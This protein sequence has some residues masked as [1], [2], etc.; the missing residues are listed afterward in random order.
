MAAD[1]TILD[2]GNLDTGVVTSQATSNSITPAVGDIVFWEAQS[3]VGT[4]AAL[5]GGG[6]T[7]SL[8]HLEAPGTEFVAVF[9]AVSG[10]PSS[11]TL[12]FSSSDNFRDSG[13]AVVRPVD[14]DTPTV[15]GNNNSGASAVDTL[16]VTLTTSSP[17]A[18]LAYFAGGANATWTADATN[19]FTEILDAGVANGLSQNLQEK[20]SNAS[21]VVGDASANVRMVA[22]ALQFLA[23]GGGGTAVKDIIG[24]GIIPFAR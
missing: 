6:L 7:W 23:S 3:S 10:T 15:V 16:T 5:S 17:A 19:G 24:S 8:V 14:L 9:K 12:T 13:W 21:Q 11:G 20:F 4:D 2:S 18:I 1:F 22:V